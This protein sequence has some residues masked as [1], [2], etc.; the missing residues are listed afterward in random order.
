MN[1]YVSITDTLFMTYFVILILRISK[2]IG[3]ACWHILGII[4]NRFSD[5]HYQTIEITLFSVRLFTITFS[6]KI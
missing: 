1:T 3:Y 5:I 4:I 6:V 2:S